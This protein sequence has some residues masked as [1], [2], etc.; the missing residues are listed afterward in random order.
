MLS[1]FQKRPYIHSVAKLRK[2]V[3]TSALCRKSK[4]AKEKKILDRTYGGALIC[5]LEVGTGG[6]PQK[7][8][9]G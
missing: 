2:L 3:I 4:G 1:A 9:G 6:M 7:T 8:L 5:P